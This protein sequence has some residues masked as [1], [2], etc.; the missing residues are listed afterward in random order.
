MSDRCG[1]ENPII[2]NVYCRR[3][4]GHTVGYHKGKATR[5]AVNWRGHKHQYTYLWINEDGLGCSQFATVSIRAEMAAHST[6]D[7]GG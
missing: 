5:T 3:P 4:A 2:G 1:D 7:A 6:E